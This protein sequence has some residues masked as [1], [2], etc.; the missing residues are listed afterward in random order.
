RVPDS[1]KFANG[2]LRQRKFDLAAEEYEQFLSSGP[3]GLDRV[4]AQFGLANARLYQG[5]YQEARRTFDQFLKSA[6]HDGRAL[7]ARY[8]PGELAYLTGDLGAARQALEAFTATTVDHPG[9]ETA[10]TYLGDA[11]FG[12]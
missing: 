9:L 7:T 6:P 1:L 11:C 8:R 3:T 4:D 2:L 5:R 12:L 10:W